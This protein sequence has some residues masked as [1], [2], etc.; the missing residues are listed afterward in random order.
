MVNSA[1]KMLSSSDVST[2]L[3]KEDNDKRRIRII[4][5]GVRNDNEYRRNVIKRAKL[6]GES[7]VSHS[8]KYK[9][10]AEIGPDCK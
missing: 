10:K 8:G 9:S 1:I 6:C 7:Y 3:I 2:S 4:K 5:R